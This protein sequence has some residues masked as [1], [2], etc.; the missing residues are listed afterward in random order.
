[1]LLSIASLGILTVGFFLMPSNEAKR[2]KQKDRLDKLAS[3]YDNKKPEH[4][5]PFAPV[6]LEKRMKM[7]EEKGAWPSSG[8]K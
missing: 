8:S 2:Q 5:N 1:M 7:L 6:N 4:L 3:K